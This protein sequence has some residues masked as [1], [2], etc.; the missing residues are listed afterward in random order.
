MMRWINHLSLATKLRLAIVCAA[1]A[2]LLVACG[3]YVTGEAFGL[4]SFELM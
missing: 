2:T 4:R 3:L 1:A